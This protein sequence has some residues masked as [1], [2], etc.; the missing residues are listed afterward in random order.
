MEFEISKS[1]TGPAAR[2][3]GRSC[4]WCTWSN[5]QFLAVKLARRLNA[6]PD[7][8]HGGGFRPAFRSVSVRSTPR[9]FSWPQLPCDITVAELCYQTLSGCHPTR[10]HAPCPSFVPRQLSGWPFLGMCLVPDPPQPSLPAAVHRLRQQWPGR[11][12]QSQ[13]APTNSSSPGPPLALPRSPWLRHRPRCDVT[14]RPPPPALRHPPGQRDP[15]AVVTPAGP[16]GTSPKGS[17]FVPPPVP[18]PPVGC[19]E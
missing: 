7:S 18:D 9:P 13:V 6:K 19:E 5:V 12:A 8:A 14:A 16:A 17:G 11:R 3:K 2:E 4:I 1:I 15:G 10:G